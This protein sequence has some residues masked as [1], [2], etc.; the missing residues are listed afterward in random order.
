MRWVFPD[1]HAF[2]LRVFLKLKVAVK[3]LRWMERA[4]SYSMT[5][6]VPDHR[7]SWISA[8]GK[9]V[10]MMFYIPSDHPSCSNTRLYKSDCF[11]AP[12]G[13]REL[14]ILQKYAFCWDF[15]A[16]WVVLKR[17]TDLSRSII[18][19]HFNRVMS[20]IAD[21]TVLDSCFMIFQQMANHF[22]VAHKVVFIELCV[23]LW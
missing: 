14:N 15:H 10:L 2:T 5:N 3:R 17:L 18:I 9:S 7:A 12:N 20:L 13:S 16:D 19:M 22:S 8:E 21:W 11:A 1:Q 4:L 6:S 23:K